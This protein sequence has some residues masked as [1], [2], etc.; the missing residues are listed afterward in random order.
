MRHNGNRFSVYNSEEK[1]VLGLLD[2]LGSLTNNVCDSLDN[3]T[4]LHGDHKG[5]WQGLNKPT[6]SEEGMRATVENIIDN[7]IPSIQTSLD[8]IKSFTIN[9]KDYG[10]KGDGVTDDTIA[11]KNA[12]NYAETL[13]N[14]RMVDGATIYF[15]SGK[16]NISET[17]NI[18]KSGISI[19]GDSISTTLKDIGLN[20]YLFNFEGDLSLYRISL[21]NL[22]LS[23][24]NQQK[25]LIKI[26]K[27]I[28]SQF[29]NLI[30]N[31]S[32]DCFEIINAGK[33][34]FR[35]IVF[36]QDIT[37]TISRYAFDI[38]EGSD[39]HFTDIQI[40][41]NAVPT[42]PNSLIIRSCDGL[43]FNNS[44]WHGTILIQPNDNKT[45]A[46][47][48]FNNCYFDR[49]NS[50]CLEIGGSTTNPYRNFM[51][52]NCYF[53][54]CNRGVTISTTSIVEL[55]QFTGCSFTQNKKDG[56]FINS[57]TKNVIFNGCSFA[58]NNVNNTST[59]SHITNTGQ[60]ITINNCQFVRGGNNGYGV[61]S[62]GS[63]CSI[64]NNNFALCEGNKL[65]ITGGENSAINN[66]G[67]ITKAVG[68]ATIPTGL[69]EVMVKHG[70]TGVTSEM[71]MVVPR[72]LVKTNYRIAWVDETSFR[73]IINS[74]ESDSTIFTYWI[75]SNLYR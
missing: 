70:L 6:M 27:M 21:S 60:Y 1:T 74:A 30:I 63:Y 68:S 71:I 19:K 50:S 37:T 31:N 40:F 65:K 18:R 75:D 29:E 41:A 38:T 66:T 69:T 13:I 39:V 17:L 33:V 73:I 64:T 28:N 34:F 16:Y 51:F 43:Y 9:I 44:H 36:S 61:L 20:N 35:N 5:T 58:D 55:I 12:I 67:I 54:D 32:Y 26:N 23:S 49:G 4:D 24:N 45:L 10:A 47:I 46:S 22:T 48:F 56:V 42:L 57:N 72:S 8:N 15:P 3:K 2:E 25:K 11:I 52:S 59:G 53:R 62:T 14:D 7:K